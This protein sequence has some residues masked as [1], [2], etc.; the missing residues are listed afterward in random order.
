MSRDIKYWS[1][2][3]GLWSLVLSLYFL[4]LW[5]VVGFWFCVLGAPLKTSVGF[6][7]PHERIKYQ[8]PKTQDHF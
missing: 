1:L 8:I 6:K 2:V 3:F 5:S 4:G 7:G